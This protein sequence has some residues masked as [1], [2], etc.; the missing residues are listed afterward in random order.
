[1]VEIQ[2]VMDENRRGKKED[3]RKKKPQRKNIMACPI[4]YGGHNKYS[5]NIP[6]YCVNVK[7]TE[8]K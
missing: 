1:M 4:P 2:S 5:N 7:H 8:A 6:V 3:R